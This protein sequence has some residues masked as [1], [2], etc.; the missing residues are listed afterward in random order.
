LND[1]QSIYRGKIDAIL[2]VA[3]EESPSRPEKL[4]VVREAKKIKKNK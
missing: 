2:R 4:S 3:A 1:K